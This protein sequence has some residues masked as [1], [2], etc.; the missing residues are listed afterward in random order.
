KFADAYE[1]SVPGSL[2]FIAKNTKPGDRIF[3]TGPPGLYV[4]ADRMSATRECGHLDAVL[5]GYPGNTDEERL[6]G[7]KAQLEKHMPK[8]VV[9]DPINEGA[10]EKHLRLLLMP[11]LQS[12]G[13]KK[14]G[15][16][17]WLRHSCS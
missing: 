3:T 9:L 12:H 11:F 4:Q 1:E 16:R 5:W 17:L 10:K 6:S 15:E 8:V 13:Y 2:A 14:S 7:L